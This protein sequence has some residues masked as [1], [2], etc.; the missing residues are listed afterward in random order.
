MLMFMNK[1]FAFVKPITKFWKY[2][3]YR[4]NMKISSH[5]PI[6]LSIASWV[7]GRVIH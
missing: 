1:E 5:L 7:L 6:F 2:E 4:K 3:P